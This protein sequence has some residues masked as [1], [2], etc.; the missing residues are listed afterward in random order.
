MMMTKT[1]MAMRTQNWVSKTDLTRYLRCP[2]AFYLLDRG[3]VVFEDAVDQQQARLIAEG[4]NFQT[5][6]EAAA[7]P[8]TIDLAKLSQVFA[9]ESIQLFR[10]PVVENPTLEIY[11]KPDAIDTAQGALVPVEVKS[12]KDVQ[13]F[14]ELELAFYWMLLEPYRTKAVSPRGYLVVR[15]NGVDAGVE[16]EIRPHRFAKVHALLQTIRD[17][18][19]HGVTPRICAC[20]VCSGVMRNEID[21]ATLAKKDLT[22]IWGIGRV[23]ARRLEE[24]G[25]ISYDELLGVDSASVA[26][27][28][29]EQ[30]YFV[31]P[32]QVDSW[33]HHAA[34]Y[35][36]SSPVLFGDPL[37]LDGEFLALDLE[38]EPGGIIWL[39]G[40]CIV[41][42][43]GREYFALWAETPAQEMSNLKRLAE[44]AAANPLLSVVTW[45]GDSADMPQLRKAVQR[46]ML[47]QEL[48]MV[49][50]RHFDL[51][52]HAQKA[53]RLPIPQ[54]AL[55]QVASY[56][57]IS[58]VSRI[59][60]GR[61]ALY[62]Y[63]EY[64]KS[65][66]ESRRNAIKNDLLEYNRD[67]LEALVGIA[68]RISAL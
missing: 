33:K 24:I 47:G 5:G 63:Q 61:A 11:G 41:R 52:Q 27:K 51:F 57:A 8:R 28:L 22:R 39:V 46:L 23:C 37:T 6:V 31:S 21:R 53:V 50:S 54:L 32:A 68:E 1:A 40:V 2:Y 56:F 42:P 36:T 49:E 10:V 44:I 55:S 26:E 19:A 14:D 58:K 25:I 7:V 13:P 62:Q 43:N 45:N 18:R 15:R 17:A 64:R 66:D 4:V 59:P 35:S 29:G 38:Y 34:S 30:R 3:L 16:V 48:D 12:H 60:D 65:R 20:T 67:D 9:E